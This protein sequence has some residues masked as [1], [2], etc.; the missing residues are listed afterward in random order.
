LN[1]THKFEAHGKIKNVDKYT[2]NI[3]CKKNMKYT[4]Y[5][6]TERRDFCYKIIPA[7]FLYAVCST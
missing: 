6:Q 1:E 4:H 2:Y 3:Q 7:Q 5:S